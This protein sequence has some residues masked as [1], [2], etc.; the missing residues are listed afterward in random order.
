MAVAAPSGAGKTSLCV[1][2]TQIFPRLRYAVSYTTRKPRAGEVD[3]HHYHFVD[4]AIFQQMVGEGRF[5]E[6]AE[7]HGNFYGT[8]RD[9]VDAMRGQGI[10]VLLD[11]DVQ[12]VETIRSLDTDGLFVMILPPS[13]EVLRERLTTRGKDSPDEVERRMTIAVKETARIDLF[14]YV[15]INDDLDVAAR[16]LES[17]IRAEHSR[18]G[19]INDN[20]FH[21]TFFP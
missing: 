5:L 3:G 13:Y 6:W 20:W 12:G 16:T 1:R 21:E 7:V 17:V 8:P 15:I 2:M 9:E 18:R 19:Q 11:M 14:D 4:R 10:D